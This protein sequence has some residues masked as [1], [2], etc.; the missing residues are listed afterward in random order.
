MN[1]L[2]GESPSLDFRTLMALKEILFG[3][4]SDIPYIFK[5]KKQYMSFVEELIEYLL[6]HH[7]ERDLAIG[8]GGMVGFKINT[9]KHIIGMEIDEHIKEVLDEL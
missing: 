2:T 6:A 7:Y 3:V 9:N 8:S 4:N 1:K 5:S